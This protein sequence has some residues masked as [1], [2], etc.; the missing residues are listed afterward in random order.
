MTGSD[1]PAART[2]RLMV[3]VSGDYGELG[4]A[5][6]FLQGLAL[7]T[8][9][10]VLLPATMAGEPLDAAA[11]QVRHY[12]HL[13][14]LRQALREHAPD[15]VLL[16][17]GYLLM[18]GARFSLLNAMR[19][20]RA[21]RAQGARLYTSDPFLGLL[22]GPLAT[23]FT[24]VL[25]SQSGSAVTLRI[26][27]LSRLLGLRLF[28]L[29]RA[30]RR[31]PHLYPAP[32]EGMP[33]SGGTPRL[34]YS[35]AAARQVPPL[36]GGPPRWLFVLSRVDHAVQVHRHGA[37]FVQLL[38]QRLRDGLHAGVQV[39]LVAP[40]A[41]CAQV[42]A[43][44]GPDATR[45]GL[46]LQGETTYHAFMHTLM[47]AHCAFFW[48]EYSFSILHRVLARRPVLYFDTGHMVSI[49]PTL[50]PAGLAMFYGGWQPPL[51]D[52][53][54]ALTP[55]RVQ[56]LADDTVRHFAHIAARLAGGTEPVALLG[57]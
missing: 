3:V 16:F 42:R 57:P 37:G 10:L 8:P 27:V 35:S 38:A 39:H 23:D 55:E 50:G 53:R 12:H 52:T 17:S 44:L 51:L 19:L 29:Q 14:D 56:A 25:A 1:P 22:H 36:A 18:V 15:T 2:R 32:T 9:P 33:A 46:Q 41:L 28:L 24:E 43:A 40:P 45:P 11:L 54:A 7:A 13:A 49:V 5:M 4:G 30:L 26:R 6:Y 34:H 48:N 20:F 31:A 21:V 47:Q